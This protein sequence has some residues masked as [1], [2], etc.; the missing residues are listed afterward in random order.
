VRY[1]LLHIISASYELRTLW[2]CVRIKSPLHASLAF[3]RT[4]AFCQESKRAAP[5]WNYHLETF[6]MYIMYRR[7]SE[8]ATFFSS[9]LNFKEEK[10]ACGGTI[11]VVS[12][13]ASWDGGGTSGGGGM[14]ADDGRCGGLGGRAAAAGGPGIYARASWWWRVLT[15]A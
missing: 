8:L 5:T 3:T 12:R 6:T 11:A 10:R 15:R 9:L 13:R 4:T 1:S 7:G 14:A 2:R